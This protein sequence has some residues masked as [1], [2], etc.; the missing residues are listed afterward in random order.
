MK[1]SVAGLLE[2]AFTWFD[3]RNLVE[4]CACGKTV[5]SIVAGCR[6]VIG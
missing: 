6:G 3:G 1:D 5:L 2:N 4:V